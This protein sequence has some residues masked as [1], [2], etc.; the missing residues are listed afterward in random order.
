M[1]KS[2]RA[3]TGS[4]CKLLCTVV[5]CSYM[6]VA[7]G[8]RA[9][10]FC[11]CYSLLICVCRRPDII[12]LQSFIFNEIYKSMN[13][14]FTPAVRK[15]LSNLSYVTKMEK[16]RLTSF[17]QLYIHRKHTIKPNPVVLASFSNSLFNLTTLVH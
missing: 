13:K 11:S 16:G 8:S 4:Q 1:L 9:A 17:F 14:Y 3:D 10:E 7:V 5:M 6:L 12:T 15:E 2:I